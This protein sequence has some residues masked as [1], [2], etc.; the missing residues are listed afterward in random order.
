MEG[1]S[2]KQVFP[3]NFKISDDQKYA[4]FT[5]ESLIYVHFLSLDSYQIRLIQVLKGHQGKVTCLNYDSLS[6]KLI[7]GGSDSQVKVWDFAS[8]VCF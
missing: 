8:G 6:Q 4:C 7:S 3:E 5:I 1:E 2:G